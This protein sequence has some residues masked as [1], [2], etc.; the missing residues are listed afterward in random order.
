M[1]CRICGC[2]IKEEAKKCTVCGVKTESFV[3]ETVSPE[4][5]TEKACGTHRN[6]WKKALAIGIPL[7]IIALLIG[8]TI[9][10]LNQ[11]LQPVTEG[12]W[13]DDHFELADAEL[14][15]TLTEEYERFASLE[16]DVSTESMICDAVV[17]TSD[18]KTLMYLYRIDLMADSPFGMLISREQYL[19]LICESY[20]TDETFSAYGMARQGEPETV[21]VG[22]LE[23]FCVSYRGAYRDSNGAEHPL[24]QRMLVNKTDRTIVFI[25]V[26]SSWE[27]S[28]IDALLEILQPYSAH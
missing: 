25:D 11:K 2:E 1:K 21:T 20:E 7:L 10:Y 15:M 26:A 9:F 22:N 13:L 8:A 28:D 6:G 19:E 5:S 27:E 3:S 16:K 12:I 17:G 4:K 24:Y 18:Q 23:F 14:Q